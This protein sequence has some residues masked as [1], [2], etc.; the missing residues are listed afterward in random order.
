MAGWARRTFNLRTS[1]C[2]I[3]N[4]TPVPT[5]AIASTAGPALSTTAGSELAKV[6]GEV[7]P[8]F[9]AAAGQTIEVDFT[10]ENQGNTQEEGVEV[11]F[12]FSADDTITTLD[13]RL[14]GTAFDFI[15]NDP[16]TRRVTVDLP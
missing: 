14:G 8:R 9:I 3:G 4:T 6:G 11:G 13:Q 12:Y 15:R 16:D 7:E 2:R 1:R 10:F 5:A